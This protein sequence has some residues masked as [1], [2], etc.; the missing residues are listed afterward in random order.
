MRA[1]LPAALLVLVSASQ[2]RAY[3][4]A[5]VLEVGAGYVGN[6]GHDAIPTGIRGDLGLLVGLSQTL[7]LGL[8]AEGG[9]FLHAGDDVA[10]VSPVAELV[11]AIDVV[12]V[13]PRFGF[14]ARGIFAFGAG[15]ATA[16][17]GLDLALG[18]DFLPRSGPNYGLELRATFVPLD[19]VPGTGPVWLG[20]AFRVG[21]SF[22]R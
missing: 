17:L 11:Y 1:I 3:E 21:F 19:R 16:D 2:A 12:K 7:S 9:A 4:D 13:V 6:F 18:V 5:I 15:E 22:E 8:R 10:Y 20:L 14:G